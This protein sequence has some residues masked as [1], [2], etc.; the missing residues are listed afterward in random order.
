MLMHAIGST[1]AFC[2]THSSPIGEDEEPSAEDEEPR[3]DDAEIAVAG[4]APE[5]EASNDSGEDGTTHAEVVAGP[6][7]KGL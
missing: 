7:E 5:Q 4:V 2:H 1:F 6:Q 3:K